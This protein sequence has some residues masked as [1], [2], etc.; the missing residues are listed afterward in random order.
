V[1]QPPSNPGVGRGNTPEPLDPYLSYWTA[2]G[3]QRRWALP[4]NS[5]VVTVGRSSD[6]D[7]RIEWDPKVSRVHATMERIGHQWTIEDDG[8][9]RNGTFVNGTRLSHRVRL[10]D[11]DKI[12]LGDTVL[13]FCYPPQTA[14][15]QTVIGAAARRLPRLTDVQRSILMALCRPYEEHRSYATPATN[16]EI[17]D[18][19][20]LSLDAVKTHLRILFHKFGIEDLP[21]NQK[22]ARLVEMALELGIIADGHDNRRSPAQ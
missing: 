1:T 7:I 21:Q 4:T 10:R 15:Q 8:L 18:D 6:S 22:R 17:A 3:T 5:G 2:N 20:S 11:R 16:K 14:T 12:L 19:L 9:S 13:T